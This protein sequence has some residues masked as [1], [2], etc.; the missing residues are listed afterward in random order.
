MTDTQKEQIRAGV[1]QMSKQMYDAMISSYEMVEKDLPASLTE[2]QKQQVFTTLFNTCFNTQKQLLEATMT[3]VKA[4][5][6]DQDL[7]LQMAKE[8]HDARNKR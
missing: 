6:K 1:A 8:V 4:K 3:D 7:M 2:D 5:V